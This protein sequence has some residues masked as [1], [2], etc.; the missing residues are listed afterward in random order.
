MK[1]TEIFTSIQ[2]ESSYAGMPCTFVRLAGCNLRCSY[3]DTLYAM[4]G[5]M[6]FSEDQIAA[7]VAR[8]GQKLVE[9]TGGEPLMQEGTARLVKRLLDEGNTVLIETNGSV[10]IEGLDP[11]ATVIMDVKTP[12]SGM[13]GMTDLSNLAHL[14]P[15]DEVKF[16]IT[17]R[18]DYEWARQF[19]SGHAL[20][21]RCKVLLSP[22]FGLLTPEALTRWMLRDG[23]RA[24]LNLQIHKYVF[25]PDRKGV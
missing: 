11:R 25:G 7:E 8:R 15:S 13:S 6:E 23:L 18:A 22:A 24:R 3:C 14:K 5:G 20:E 9:V 1:V 4:E 21:E 10:S 16:V 12:G 17:D 2:G 19:I